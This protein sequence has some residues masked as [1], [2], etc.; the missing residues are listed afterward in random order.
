[1]QKA[2]KGFYADC[3]WKVERKMSLT[4]AGEF[5]DFFI[6]CMGERCPCFVKEGNENWCYRDYMKYPLNKKARARR[7]EEYKPFE[8][9]DF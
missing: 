9:K 8:E 6:P 4:V 5:K 2:V 1:M 7:D 3:P